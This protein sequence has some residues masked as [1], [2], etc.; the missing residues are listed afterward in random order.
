MSPVPEGGYPESRD[1]DRLFSAMLAN[2]QDAWANGDQAKLSA[3]VGKM[4]SL[5]DAARSLMRQ[6]LPGGQGNFG[7]S[8]RLIT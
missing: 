5:G 8:F 6:P 7:P 4:R 1:F 2:L 3:G